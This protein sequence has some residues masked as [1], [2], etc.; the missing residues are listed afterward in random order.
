MREGFFR[1]LLDNMFDGVYFT[2]RDRRITYWNAGAERISGYKAEDV[3]GHCCFENILRHVD[4]HG[5][6]LCVHGCPMRA[7]L[8]DGK[9]REA[10]V[11][12]HHRLGHRVPVTVRATPIRDEDG[13]ITGAVEVFSPVHGD[14]RTAEMIEELRQQAFYDQLTG[15]GNR[16]YGE[17]NLRSIGQSAS[18][19]EISAG[20]LFL[21]IDHF[22]YTND[23]FGHSAGDEVLRSV[24]QTIRNALGRNHV[25]SRWGGEEFLAILPGVERTN[26]VDKAHEIRALVE[27]TWVQVD[28]QMLRATISIGAAM[29]HEGCDPA[30]ILELA[31][32]RLYESK[33]RGRNRVTVDGGGPDGQPSGQRRTE[34]VG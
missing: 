21:D 1:D 12:M 14:D 33:Q 32:A 18:L 23:R 34:K 11:F 30:R 24:A 9:P 13:K 17:I 28:D 4:K 7:T 16:R 2:D 25:L 22:K 15:V 6:Q 27:S 26:L 3:V 31:D 29:M 10:E 5:R 20:L 8:K 19:G